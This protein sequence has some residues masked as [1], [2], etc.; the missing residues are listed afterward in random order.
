MK[1]CKDIQYCI[2]GKEIAPQ[3]KTTHYQG[4]LELKKKKRLTAMKKINPTIHWEPAKGTQKQNKTYCSKENQVEEWGEPVGQGSRS[5]LHR[6]FDLA[7][8]NST[9]LEMAETLPKA[10]AQFHE[11]ASR[12][13][14]LSREKR[15][16]QELSE[17]YKDWKPREWQKDV[18]ERLTAQTSRQVTWCVDA[19]GGSGKTELGNYLEATK[20]AFVVT[21]GKTAD[22]SYAYDYQPIVVFDWPRDMEERVPYSLIEMFKNGRIFSGKY[23][24]KSKRFKSPKVLIFTNFEPELGKLSHDRWD[25]IR[26][27]YNDD[28]WVIQ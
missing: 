2:M 24:S 28:T 5:D 10:H 1:A 16:Q 21:N 13:R 8:S 9:D 23:K 4:Y 15:V 3:T 12:V 19:T 6:L 14:Y 11:W 17:Q 25:V 22:I 18:I 7:V 26:L 27:M 20:E